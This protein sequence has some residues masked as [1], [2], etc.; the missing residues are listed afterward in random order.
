MS[1]FIGRFL[2]I[3]R[4]RLFAEVGLILLPL[5][6]VLLAASLSQ[7]TYPPDSD[8]AK[9]YPHWPERLLTIASLL[10]LPVIKGECPPGFYLFGPSIVAGFLLLFFKSRWFVLLAVLAFLWAA[11]PSIAIYAMNG[12]QMF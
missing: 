1:K 3:G 5:I 7:S 6:T 10:F 11:L 8:F 2:P 9:Y 12:G 4:S